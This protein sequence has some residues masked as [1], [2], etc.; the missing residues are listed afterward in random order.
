MGDPKLNG[1]EV[2]VHQG[3]HLV[4]LEERLVAMQKSIQRLW[5][6][7]GIWIGVQVLWAIVGPEE[8]AR[9]VKEFLDVAI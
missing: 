3:D 1:D 9:I 5:I 4:T 2:V 8:F 7:L 6:A